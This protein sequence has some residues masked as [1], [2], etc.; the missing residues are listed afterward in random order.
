MLRRMQ[1]GIARFSF[2]A[3][4][5]AHMPIKLFEQ[6]EVKLSAFIGGRMAQDLATLCE[7]MRRGIDVRDRHA[8]ARYALTHDE[9]DV[10]L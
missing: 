3:A 1:C 2:R 8:L 5:A 10:I 4:C 9:N 6:D 7:A